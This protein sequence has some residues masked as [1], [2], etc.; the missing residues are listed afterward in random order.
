MIG[1]DVVRADLLPIL[2]NPLL[3]LGALIFLLI[4][5]TL[6]MH[7][8]NHPRGGEKRIMIMITRENIRG[9]TQTIKSEAGDMMK[10]VG[11]EEDDGLVHILGLLTS[12]ELT[13]KK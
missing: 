6:G 10:R 11:D 12:Q 3:A 9:M 8:V 1:R 13:R 5:R 4:P 7:V 2:R